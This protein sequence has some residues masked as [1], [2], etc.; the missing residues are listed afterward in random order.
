M[1]EPWIRRWGSTGDERRADPDGEDL[2]TDPGLVMDHTV[3]IEAPPDRVS[4]WLALIGRDRGGFYGCEWLANL[5]R[6]RMRNTDRIH[7]EWRRR[8]IGGD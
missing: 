4:P 6:C 2:V 8:E 3:T 1:P 5:P 7:P